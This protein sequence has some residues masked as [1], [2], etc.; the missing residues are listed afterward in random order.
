[1][2]YAAGNL[3]KE[4]ASAILGN[5]AFVKDIYDFYYER[6]SKKF[7]SPEE[8]I[9]YFFNDRTAKNVNTLHIGK[10]VADA[11]MSNS[12][13]QN[14]R[15]ARIQKT[16]DSLPHFYQDGGRG[17]A[18]FWN[19]VKHVLLDPANVLGFGFG[20]ISAKAS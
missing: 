8:A 20:A 1:M 13:A 16:F 15:L 3:S 17:S 11:T 7:S 10:E 18:G 2:G 14:A 12:D 19:N 4:D 5:T 6:D 9:D